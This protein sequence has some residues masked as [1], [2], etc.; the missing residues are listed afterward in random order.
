MANGVGSLITDVHM[1][2]MRCLF[3]QREQESAVWFCPR[4]RSLP[5]VV[6]P[7]AAEGLD[8]LNRRNQTLARELGI[9]ALGLQRVAARVHHLKIT[10]DAGAITIRSEIGGATRVGDGALLSGGLVN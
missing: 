10:H 4:Q 7:A 6:L 8:K 2:L 1:K 9:G 3:S 5:H